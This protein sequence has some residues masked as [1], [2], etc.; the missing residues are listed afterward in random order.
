M[1]NHLLDSIIAFV[2]VVLVKLFDVG[3]LLFFCLS[4]SLNR[5]GRDKKNKYPGHWLILITL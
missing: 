5:V 1:I 4:H 3:L 2:N